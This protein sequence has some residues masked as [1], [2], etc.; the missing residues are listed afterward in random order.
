MKFPK[1]IRTFCSTCKKHTLQ[2]VEL[3]KKKT[4]GSMTHGMRRFD[5][6]MRGYGSFPKENP[7]GREKPTRKLDLRYVCKECK[8]KHSIGKGFRVKKLELESAK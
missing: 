6:K 4:R 2:T 7:K 5:R 1:E 8:K 3:S